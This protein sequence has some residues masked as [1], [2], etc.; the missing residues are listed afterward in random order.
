S[1]QRC[2]LMSRRTG[3]GAA[4]TARK[5]YFNS[6]CPVCN[7]G[8]ASQRKKMRASAACGDIEWLDINDDPDALASRGGNIDHGR[9][10]LYVED[11]RGELHV[12]AAAFAALWR[13]T[14]GEQWLGR[15]VSL[16]ILSTLARLAYDAFADLLYRW[17]R[18]KGRW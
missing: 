13:Q 14:P 18:H 1:Y 12:G 16:P 15:V 4:M 10:K 11:D 5:V 9:R 7:A 17:N 8:V 3:D 2:R 6:T